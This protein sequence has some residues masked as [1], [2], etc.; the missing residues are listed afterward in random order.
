M[1]FQKLLPRLMSIVFILFLR[2]YISLSYK[3]M[4]TAS[5]T[6]DYE[7]KELNSD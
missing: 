6:S 5:A 7:Q 3:I 4:G 2:V 1:F